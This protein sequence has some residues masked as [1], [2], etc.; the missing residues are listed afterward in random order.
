MFLE[1]Y[2]AAAFVLIIGLTLR[3]RTKTQPAVGNVI[4][5]FWH[6]DMIPLLIKH[7][8]HK[9]TIL[10]SS[11]KD[12]EL[13]AGP[14]RILGYR[15]VRGSSNRKS[16]SSLKKLAEVGKNNTLGVTPDGPKGPSHVAKTGVV[17]L[18]YITGNPIIPIAVDI[19]PEITF[20]S[21]DK[22]R[23]PLLF[24]KINL[25]YGEPI[26]VSHKDEFETKLAELQTAME[27]L[28]SKN[29]I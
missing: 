26:F 1:K 23:F 11:S 22:F 16:I 14:A 18:S 5:A 28:E 25:S 3:F 13:I 10:V 7:K 2:L 29:K 6:R 17:F 19:K 15:T 12:G 21:W 8:F 20:N 24:S 27:K 9:F 4:Y